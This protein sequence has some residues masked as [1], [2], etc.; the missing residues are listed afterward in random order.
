M[1]YDSGKL[2]FMLNNCLF[3]LLLTSVLLSDAPS[4]RCCSHLLSQVLLLLVLVQKQHERKPTPQNETRCL[5]F[6]IL[7]GVG[8]GKFTGFQ[9]APPSVRQTV[10]HRAFSFFLSV[11]FLIITLQCPPPLSPDRILG[12]LFHSTKHLRCKD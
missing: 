2:A 12:L 9:L 3:S 4:L 10:Q 1:C 8:K 11:F 7:R 6:H 5:C